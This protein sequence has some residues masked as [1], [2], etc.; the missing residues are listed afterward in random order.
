MTCDEEKRNNNLY[1]ATKEKLEEL[2]ESETD[3]KRLSDSFTQKVKL[4]KKA[5][6]QIKMEMADKEEIKH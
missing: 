6:H 2:R 4:R 5:V 3:L 1:S